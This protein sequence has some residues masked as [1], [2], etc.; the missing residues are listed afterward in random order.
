MD[1]FKKEAESLKSFRFDIDFRG[2]CESR[3]KELEM[4]NKFDKFWFKAK[5]NIKEAERIFVI[6]RKFCRK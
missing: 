4:I 3:K 5:V 2:K 1:E 6:F